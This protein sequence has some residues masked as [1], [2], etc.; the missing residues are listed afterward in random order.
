MWE[1]I[2]FAAANLKTALT[3]VKSNRGLVVTAF[4]FLVL[5]LVWSLFWSIAAGGL[6]SNSGE[7]TLFLT[8]VSYFWVRLFLKVL[9]FDISPYVCLI[10]LIRFIVFTFNLKTYKVFQNTLVCT[11]VGTVGTWWFAP[12]EATS[13]FSQ[14]LKDSI[15]R[16]TTYS[17]GSICFG[18]LLVAI[19]QALRQLQRHAQS[20]GED[21]AIVAC[22]ID[23]ILGC[24]QGIIE[25][26]N[27]WAYVYVGLYGY[28]YIEAGKNVMQ[29]FQSKGWTAIITDDLVDN[30]LFMVSIGIGLISGLIAMLIAEVDRQLLAG[31]GYEDPALAAFFIGFI[32]GLVL[33]SVLLSVVGSAGA[34]L[35]S[36]TFCI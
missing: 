13:F 8:F 6:L 18:S 32:V 12:Q 36:K 30:V 22:L 4:L 15:F 3:S 2:P 29:L 20:Q 24:I 27:K 33:A 19:V 9:T 16:A 10:C 11:T 34:L 26:V 31:I 1:R 21:G 7:F 35:F 17:F 23:C 14:G 5:A 28:S 25:Y